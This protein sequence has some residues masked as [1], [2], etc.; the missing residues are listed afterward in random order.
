L[1]INPKR[2][3]PRLRAV[4]PGGPVPDDRAEVARAL[5][6][7]YAP[8]LPVISD[9]MLSFLGHDTEALAELLVRAETDPSWVEELRARSLRLRGLIDPA[10]E[11]EAW[12]RLL[13]DLWRIAVP[14]QQ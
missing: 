10:R 3:R 4:P 8:R 13:S 6:T 5:L 9:E 1:T 12:A 7:R 11:R 14:I 2:G